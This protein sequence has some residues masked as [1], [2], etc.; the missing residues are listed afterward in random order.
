[1]KEINIGQVVCSTAGRDKGHF[2]VVLEVLDENFAL[3]CNGKIRKVSHPKKKK[4]KHLAKTNH[5][6]KEIEEKKIS[7]K[8]IT[9]AE[10]RKILE[11]YHTLDSVGDENREEV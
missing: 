6:V 5:I 9:N 2:M 4:I 3:V 1:M 7:G 11:S 8:K 10:I